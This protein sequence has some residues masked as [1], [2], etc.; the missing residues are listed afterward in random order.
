MKSTKGKQRFFL[1]FYTK[2]VCL[3]INR[4]VSLIFFLLLYATGYAQQIT[5]ASPQKI[6]MVDKNTKH[7]N[8]MEQE[9]PRMPSF[10]KLQPKAGKVCGYVKDWTGRP[11][12]GAAIGVRSSYFA[13]YYSGGKAKTDAHGYYELTPPKG[14]AHFYNAGYQLKY[15]N[16]T[17]A[18]SLHPADGVLDSWTTTDGLV[19]NFVLLP[20]GITS[21][22][23]LQNNPHL[24]GSFY[25]GAIFLSWYGVEADDGNAPGFAIREGTMV[26]ITL[27]PESKTMADAAAQSFVIRKRAGSYGELR[28]HNIP[29]AHYKIGITA[30]GKPVILKDTRKQNPAF[31]LIPAQATGLASIA[32]LPA[33]TDAS[34][35]APQS[36]AWDWINLNLEMPAN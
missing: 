1:R 12:A 10:P 35:L 27:T 29:I 8:V 11:L 4:L 5:M 22:E 17:V 31:G 34:L 2:A 36:G 3:H 30:N 32:F 23:N 13:G 25:G 19:E 24:P 16:S 33:H 26:E 14:S 9:M 15:G 7:I 6:I 20:Y 28:I 18:V 21:R